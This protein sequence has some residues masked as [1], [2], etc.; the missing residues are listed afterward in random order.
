MHQDLT[1]TPGGNYLSENTEYSLKNMTTA[2]VASDQDSGSRTVVFDP[3]KETWTDGPA[4]TSEFKAK[5]LIKYR[6][7]LYAVCITGK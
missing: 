1:N 5:G 2:T 7:A 3:V 4:L 6:G